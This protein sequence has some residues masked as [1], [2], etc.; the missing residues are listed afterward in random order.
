MRKHR[1]GSGAAHVLVIYK[2]S[3]YQIYVREKKNQRIQQLIDAGDPSIVNMEKAHKDHVKSIEEARKVLTQLGTKAIFRHRS[4]TT[5][6][7]E[8]D[9]LVTLGGD[10]TL[11]WASHIAGSSCPVVAINTAPAYSTGYFCAGTKQ[12]IHRVL[13]D[14]LS[15][16]LKKTRLSRMHVELDGEKVSSR[17]LNDT[18]FCHEC[19]AATSRYL[20]QVGDREQEHKSSG[21][22]VGPAAGSTAAQHAAGGRIL[23]ITSKR[24]QFVVRESGSKQ[25]DDLT[26]GFINPGEKIRLRSRMR[27][28]HLYIDGPHLARSVDIGSELTMYLSDEPLTLLGFNSR[29]RAEQQ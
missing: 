8:F 15:G 14:A 20:I 17:V 10:G 28:G 26:Q 1:L 18:L 2:K 5:N 25:G 9:L 27:S 6:T 4:A 23:P 24:L 22:W 12:E 7:D 21:I 19:P 3:S 16:K 13:C 29:K 11:L